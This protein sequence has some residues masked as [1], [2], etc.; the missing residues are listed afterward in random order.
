MTGMRQRLRKGLLVALAVHLVAAVFLGWFAFNR[1]REKAP[2]II[3]IT[4]TGGGGGGGGGQPGNK[5]PAAAKE[6]VKPSS[7]LEA[8]S[9]IKDELLDKQEPETKTIPE[10]TTTP[11]PAAKQEQFQEQPAATSSDTAADSSGTDNGSGGSGSGSGGGSGSGNGTG[12]GSGEGSGSGSGSGS[13]NGS[14]NGSGSGSG[15]GP[16]SG[17]PVTAPYFIS[18]ARPRYPS[19]ALSREYQGAVRIRM[20]VNASG[21]VVSAG[22][23]SSSG[24]GQL[25]QAALNVVYGWQFSPAKD[26]YGQPCACYIT[27]PVTFVIR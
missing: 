3:E 16:G 2:Q 27:M 26:T 6:S 24:S 10:T 22:I 15:N 18:G 11:T 12:T 7:P 19:P 23:A 21:N 25:D 20:M 8:L 5:A 13:G 9:E 14:G 17:V 1:S 4:L